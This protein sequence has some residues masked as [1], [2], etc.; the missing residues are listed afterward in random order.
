MFN[1]GN[2]VGNKYIK[3]VNFS[4]AV[5]WKNREISLRTSVVGLFG[6]R[7][8]E[9]VVFEDEG[10]NERW[11]ASVLKLQAVAVL[12]TEGQEEQYYYPINTFKMSKIREEEKP[13]EDK[14]VIKPPEQSKLI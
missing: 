4:K 10:K 2:F 1:S 6:A 12:K 8:T 7:G 9:E 3:R 11:S 5:L 13:I 14:K